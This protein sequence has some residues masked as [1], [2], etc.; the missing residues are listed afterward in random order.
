MIYKMVYDE[1]N[2]ED[3]EVDEPYDE[4]GDSNSNSNSTHELIMIIKKY[5]NE[6]VM[7]SS[8]T[9]SFDSDLLR[10]F[11]RFYDIGLL[12]LQQFKILENSLKFAQDKVAFMLLLEQKIGKKYTQAFDVLEVM[13]ADPVN[14]TDIKEHL[15]RS[16]IRKIKE[17]Y[18]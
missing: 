11:R 10:F 16:I 12:T 5:Y 4:V 7:F 13:L 17:R 8:Y 15:K 9:K 14:S 1:D 2:H 3:I 18:E 6:D